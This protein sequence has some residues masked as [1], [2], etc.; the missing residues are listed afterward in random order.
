[1]TGAVGPRLSVTITVTSADAVR[2]VA[3]VMVYSCSLVVGPAVT[4]A[5]PLAANTV[6]GSLE[7]PTRPARAPSGSMSLAN[8][9]I[10]VAC[11]GWT[12]PTTSSTATGGTGVS[13][14][15]TSIVTV[16]SSTPPLPSLIEY[17]TV[18]DSASPAIV[19]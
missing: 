16:A 19:R 2:P 10:D 1:M 4:V 15:T 9:S 17:T 12:G 5:V 6:A 8:R 18:C 7:D 11:P 14:L 3:S 13:E